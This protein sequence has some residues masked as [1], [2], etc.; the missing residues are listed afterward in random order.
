[1]SE[2]IY[3]KSL[4]TIYKVSIHIFSPIQSDVCI[5]QESLEILLDICLK[6]PGV[7]RGGDSPEVLRSASSSSVIKV[8]CALPTV[9]IIPGI[10]LLAINNVRRLRLFSL[11]L[12]EVHVRAFL[13][14]LN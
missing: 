1:M 2:I 11:R 6:R 13:Q 14:N 5:F 10:V 7:G 9:Q 3:D 8:V 4:F 12:I